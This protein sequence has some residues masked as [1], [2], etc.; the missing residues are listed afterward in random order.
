MY[1]SKAIVDKS[2]PATGLDSRQHEIRSLAVCM[3]ALCTGAIVLRVWSKY[4]PCTSK[5][6]EIWWDDWVAFVSLVYFASSLS[7]RTI[8]ADL[9]QPFNLAYLGLVVL[10]TTKGLGQ[11]ASVI[12]AKALALGPIYLYAGTFLYDIAIN[13]PKFSA[14]FFYTRIFQVQSKAFKWTL[15]VLHALLVVWLLLAIPSTVL[16]CTPVRKAWVPSTPGH[17]VDNYRWLLGSA[18]SSVLNDVFILLTPLPWLW[19][20]QMDTFRKVSLTVMFICAYWYASTFTW[21]TSHDRM[22]LSHQ[23]AS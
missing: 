1:I 18:V 16:Q 20:L 9:C 23:G 5:N 3:M 4:A 11:H 22:I 21:L 6:Q 2:G 14:V 13:L 10:W 17:C 19:R 12:P 8:H 15:W 7:S